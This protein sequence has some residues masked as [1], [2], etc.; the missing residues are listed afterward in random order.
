MSEQ[1]QFFFSYKLQKYSWILLLLGFCHSLTAQVPFVCQNNFYFSLSSFGGGPSLVHEVILSPNGV[2]TFNPLSQTTGTNINAIGYR[3]TDNLIYGV[4]TSDET[5]YK[6]DATGEGFPLTVLDVNHS[7]GYYAGEITPN[8]NEMII[9][10]SG[11][12][13]TLAIIKI[14]LTND[15][16]PVIARIPLTGTNIL[17]TDIAFDPITGVMYGFDAFASR[18]VIIDPNSGTVTTPFPSSNVA[19]RMG[20]LYFDAFGNMF[21]Y[22]NAKNDNQAKTFFGI[23]KENGNVINLATG[24][25]A[26]SKDGCACPYTIDLL[27]RVS[28]LVTVPC[29]EVTYTFEISNLSGGI[30]EGIDLTDTMPEDF[31]IQRIERNP[32]GGIV[33]GIGTNILKIADMN[34]PLGQDSITVIIETQP[35]AEGIYKNQALLENLPA[36]LGNTIVSDNPETFLADDSTVLEIIPLIVDLENQKASLCEG[37]TIELVA[38]FLEG[39]DYQWNTG[40]TASALNVNEPGL[41][42]VTITNGCQT[43]FDSVTIS[44]EPISVDLEEEIIINL[45]ETIPITPMTNAVGSVVYDWSN[46]SV[47][48][49]CLDCPTLEVRPLFDT[50][51]E[52]TIT[53]SS[54]CTA[55]DAVR[56]LVTK[57]RGIYIPNVFSPNGDQKNDVFFLMGKGF[58]DIVNFQIFDRW[59]NQ[60]FEQNNGTINDPAFGW[61]GSMDNQIMTPQVFMF[62]AKV[63][64]L[65]NITEE[66]WGN[67]TLMR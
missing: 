21:G 14:D 47:P 45:G 57:E 53:S 25:I 33:S 26:S 51:Y 2:A 37:A 23:N 35:F 30:Q 50:N 48:L 59:G 56:I 6:I 67:V 46:Q 40:S 41:Y 54:G 10:E 18:L 24:P 7:N 4:R 36:A 31:I 1:K 17:S 43:V 29:T 42:T 22:G 61:D 8:G 11:R 19:D 38:G 58:A 3:S 27:K 5:L 34:V 49:N 12:S 13:N 15:Q 20:G 66:F 63:I 52:L 9:L 55:K 65:D 39:I 16:Y 64:Y 60:V 28:P 32:Y 62:Y 44:E